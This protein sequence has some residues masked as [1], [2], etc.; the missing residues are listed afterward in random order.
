MDVSMPEMDGLEATALI[1]SLSADRH[2]PIIAMTAHAL[3]GDREMCLNAGMD[4]Y[5]SK[6]IRASDL[7]ATIADVL[8]RYPPL[9]LIQPS[10][11]P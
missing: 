10:T 7:S 11:Y 1:R 6:P 9:R 2:I 4:G 3:I 8:A 5:I